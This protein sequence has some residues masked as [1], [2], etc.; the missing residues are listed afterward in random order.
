MHVFDIHVYIYHYAYTLC[1]YMGVQMD[2]G[3]SRCSFGW[4]VAL[5]FLLCLLWHV[6]CRSPDCHEFSFLTDLSSSERLRP[7]HEEEELKEREDGYLSLY[8]WL[9]VYMLTDL[10]MRSHIDV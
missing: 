1:L 6:F 2:R 4:L 5:S 3:M 10:C 9:Y 7:L 8:R